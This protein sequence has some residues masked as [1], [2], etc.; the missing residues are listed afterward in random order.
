[1]RPGWIKPDTTFDPDKIYIYVCVDGIARQ[2]C[3]R[4]V[5]TEPRLKADYLLG[6]V[7][8]GRKTCIECFYE[9]QLPREEDAVPA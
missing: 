4:H 5:H 7:Q 1:M 2:R 6:V 3:G 9:G 8:P